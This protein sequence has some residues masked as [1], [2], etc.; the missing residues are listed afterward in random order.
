MKARW[1]ANS[2]RR[3]TPTLC[4]SVT[5]SRPSQD[6]NIDEPNK[7]SRIGFFL[8]NRRAAASNWR[9][10]TP[11]YRGGDGR[12]EVSYFLV[13]FTGQKEK[14]MLPSHQKNPIR[15]GI[16]WWAV[17]VAAVGLATPAQA[18]IVVINFDSLA[19]D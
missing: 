15:V 3:E 4:G 9:I 11:L 13:T 16:H 10:A 1:Q 17:A 19:Q 14:P 8:D 6:S 7:V 12:A 2:R 5:A 18:A